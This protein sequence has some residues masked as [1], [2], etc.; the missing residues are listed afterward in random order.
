MELLQLRYFLKLAES[1]HLTNTARELFISAPSL[2]LTI[3]R[4]EKE[5]GVPLFDRV[6]RSIVLNDHGQ[7]FYTHIK[8][9]MQSIDAGVSALQGLP[10]KPT[11]SLAL[12]SPHAW[13]ACLFDFQAAYPNIHLTTK[14]ISA[15]EIQTLSP[16]SF[17]FFIAI[18]REID[19]EKFDYRV[20]RRPEKP[21]VVLSSDHPLARRQSVTFQ[22]L[23]DEVFITMTQGLS[24]AY[25]F[26]TDMCTLA[27]CDIP[28]TIESDLLFRVTL[29]EQ[30]QG[31]TLTTDIGF[32][33][34][35]D[36]A[37]PRIKAIPISEPMLTR[38]Q[39]IAWRKGNPPSKAGR[40]FMD[41]LLSYY[42]DV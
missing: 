33:T 13:G 6:G 25:Q 9:A 41:F 16:W 12:A 19:T 10:F 15:K 11:V 7:L 4:L 14:N 35:F 36:Q 5:L 40:Q 24:T 29:I 22:E 27:E 3:T 42:R 23:K 17:D 32:R 1:Q 31:I 18:V 21:V 26:L 37:N 28:K 20:I 34:N 8:Q 39:A 30:M 2:S 38:T